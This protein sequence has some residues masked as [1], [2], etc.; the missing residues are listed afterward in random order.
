MTVDRV[1]VHQAHCCVLHGCKYGANGCPVTNGTFA[2]DYPCEQCSYED[3]R[4]TYVK[5]GTSFD[6]H[7]R[8]TGDGHYEAFVYLD[9][10]IVFTNKEPVFKYPDG[11]EDFAG[12]TMRKFAKRLASLLE[13]KPDAADTTVPFRGFRYSWSG[14]TLAL[15]C[16]WCESA[17]P[18]VRENRFGTPCNNSWHIGH[19]NH[20]VWIP[21]L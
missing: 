18:N 20:K 1:G 3:A 6:I 9:V 10:E 5:D 21:E 17:D 19:P 12:V 2:Q 14:G 13:V 7:A 15:V 11:I 16:P 4:D 8:T